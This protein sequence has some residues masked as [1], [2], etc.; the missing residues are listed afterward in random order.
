MPVELVDINCK[1]PKEMNDV[2]VFVVELLKDMKAGKDA[3]SI[4]SENLANGYKAIEGASNIPVEAKQAAKE[5]AV[6][7]GH[8]GAEILGVFL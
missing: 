4:L 6:L 8:M 7:A 3:A 2:K 1:V 5:S